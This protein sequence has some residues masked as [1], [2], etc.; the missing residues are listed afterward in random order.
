MTTTVEAVNS[1]LATDPLL[2]DT[3]ARGFISLRRTARKLIEIYGWETTEEAVVSALRRYKEANPHSPLREARR[4]LKDL[5]VSVRGGLAL[6]TI[7]RMYE[8][9][10]SLLEAWS[11]TG[12]DQIL[13]VYPAI[14]STLV[15]LEADHLSEFTQH[16]DP[17]WVE[18]TEAPISAIRLTLREEGQALSILMIALTALAHHGIDVIDLSTSPPEYSILVHADSAPDAYGILMDLRRGPPAPGGSTRDDTR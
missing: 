1:H 9:Q 4:R 8:V 18:H 10:E 16:L 14:K 17:R 13:G 2:A 11:E 5:S 12:P 15:L 3:L 7:P 6:V